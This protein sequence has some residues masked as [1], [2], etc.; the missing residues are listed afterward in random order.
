MF[1]L[2]RKGLWAHK[3]R[4]LLTGLAVV[5]GVAFMAGTMILTDTMGKT[6]DGLFATS[7]ESIDVVVHRTTGVDGK[8]VDVQERVEASLVDRIRAVDG[9]DAAAGTVEGFAQLVS[10]DGTAIGT[11]GMGG[12]IGVSWIA[13]ERL[14]PFDLSAGHAPGPGEIVLDQATFES[15]GWTLGD[16]VGV[17][18][19]DATT[20]MT[21]VGTATFGDVKGVPGITVVAAHDTTAQAMFAKPGTYDSVVVAS[22]GGSTN[23][24]LADRVQAVVGSDQL[25]VVTGD[26]DTADKQANFKKDMAFF[27]TFLLAFAYIALFV[28]MFIIYNTFSI[29][30][31]QRMREM[32]MLRAVGASRRQVLRAVLLESAIVGLVA[33]GLGLVAGVG[34]SFGL[35]ALLAGVGLEIPDGE[36]VISTGTVVTAFAVGVGVTLISSIGPAVRASRIRPIAALRETAVESVTTPV[37]RTVAGVLVTAA[38]LVAFAAGIAGSGNG[39]VRLLGLGVLTVILGVFVLGPAIARPAIR[40]IGLPTRLSGA[41]G[42]LALEN[43]R[44]NPRRTAATASALMIGVALVGFITILA[45][46]TKASTARA[47]DASLRADYVVD[48]GSW[49]N[50]GFGP[51]IEEDLAAVPGVETLSPM[52]STPVNLASGASEVLAV[53]TST[54]DELMDLEVAAGEITDVHGDGL[55]VGSKKAEE[56]GLGLGDTMTVSFAATGDVDLTVRALFDGEVLGAGG[57][58]YVVGLDTFEANVTDQF[59]RQVYVQ[60]ADG[61]DAAT[62]TAAIE[63]ALTSWPNADLQDQAGFKEA[64]TSEIDMMLNLIYGLLALAVIIALIGIANTL[65][66]SVHE[67][68]RELGLLRAV[69]MTRRQL[70]TAIRWES[71]LISLFG[72]ALGF[73]LGVGGAWGITKAVADQG[74]STFVLPVQ[75]LAVIVGLAVLAGVLAAL[76]PARRAGRLNVLDAIAT[77]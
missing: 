25:E 22:D 13:D 30:I 54:I 3:V 61:T 8:G 5:L 4:F 12:T 47:V 46:S 19:N 39:A 52:R 48:S 24:E 73:V 36:L 40:L 33:S 9:V 65:A 44:R 67:R 6:F 35:R 62:T 57:S 50:G 16:T 69:G 56:L 18:A 21:I 15:E 53:D 11:D 77:A 68:T 28:G 60:L 23:A 66:L 74:V 7:N 58:A 42:H 51:S 70:R 59:D 32:A 49:G 10:S 20:D 27:T 1:N 2:T 17:L 31:A 29:I 72:T 63:D 38:G 55:A 14:N 76:G 71:V 75:Q 26:A 41:T 64:I 34:M 43:A 37:R 45:S